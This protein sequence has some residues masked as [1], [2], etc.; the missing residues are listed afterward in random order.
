MSDTIRFLLLSDAIE[1]QIKMHTS[2]VANNWSSQW[3]LLY[4]DVWEVD[5]ASLKDSECSNTIELDLCIAHQ[6]KFFLGM[7]YKE[8]K[9]SVASMIVHNSDSSL[10]SKLLDFLFQKCISSFLSDYAFDKFYPN[11]MH[12][13]LHIMNPQATQGVSSELVEVRLRNNDFNLSLYL[14]MAFIDELVVEE[15]L[16]RSPEGSFADRIVSVHHEMAE[17]NVNYGDVDISI[18]ELSTISVGDVI[19]LEKKIDSPMSVHDHKG[20]LLFNGYLGARDG[21]LALKVSGK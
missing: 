5:V 19:C 20:N 3:H 15:E 16:E 21:Q 1:Q 4:D 18:S 11:D 2:K 6:D 13:K 9:Q 17:V 12:E 7:S 8:C 10:Q 14:S